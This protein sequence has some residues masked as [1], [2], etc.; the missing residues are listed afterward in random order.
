VAAPFRYHDK[1][2]MATIGRRSAVAELRGPGPLRGQALSGSL[3]WLAWLGLHLVYLVGG[4][5][6]LV[7]FINWIWRYVGWPAGPRII[8]S[9]TV[10][11]PLAQPVDR[12]E[13]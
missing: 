1:G 2:I 8:V 7:V 6:R 4:L 9:D 5:N 13:R 3:G 11:P 10:E 12:N